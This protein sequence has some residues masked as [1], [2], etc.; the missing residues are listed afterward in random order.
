MKDVSI[1]GVDPAKRVFQLYG[2]AAK[3]EVVFRK[4]QSHPV[5]TILA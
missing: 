5:M 2:A 4:K 3:G 1:I